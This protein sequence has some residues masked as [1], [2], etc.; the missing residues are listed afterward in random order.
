MQSIFL[1]DLEQILHQLPQLNITQDHHSKAFEQVLIT[2]LQNHNTKS[3]KLNINQQNA[4]WNYVDN[5][6][7][8]AQLII[9]A[10]YLC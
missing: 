9:Y 8:K 3:H 10:N 4:T 5:E 1:E 6:I 2:Y 7:Q